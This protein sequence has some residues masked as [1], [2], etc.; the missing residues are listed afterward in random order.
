MYALEEIIKNIN[1]Y[2]IWIVLA[3]VCLSIVTLILIINQITL[4]KKLKTL[5]RG[6]KGKN[7]NDLIEKYYD[8]IDESKK[9]LVEKLEE[10]DILKEKLSKS[11]QK[12]NIIRYKAFEDVGG[13]LSFSL[14]M[15]DE[16]NDGMVLTGIHAR[17]FNGIYAKPIKNGESRY[18]LSSEEKEALDGA[19]SK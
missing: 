12:F 9:E 15:L 19:L 6:V 11:I 3:V 7:L 4:S 2:T 13:D 16:K 8:N 1:D 14:A 18:D 10:L 17:D 5:A